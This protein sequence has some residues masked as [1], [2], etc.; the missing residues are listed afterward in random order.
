M[1]IIIITTLKDDSPQTLGDGRESRWGATSEGS[2]GSHPINRF[3][4][5]PVSCLV[6]FSVPSIGHSPYF[7]LSFYFLLPSTAVKSCLAWKWFTMPQAW[8]WV[9]GTDWG[10]QSGTMR[11]LTRI[12]ISTSGSTCPSRSGRRG[13]STTTTTAAARTSTASSRPS[14]TFAQ[15]R[16]YPAF[17]G[18]SWKREITE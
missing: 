2:R 1:I 15:V 9:P 3:F 12:G 4:F 18:R 7:T 14:R 11:R 8:A 5:S 16:P 17:L 10:W 13:G 6:Q